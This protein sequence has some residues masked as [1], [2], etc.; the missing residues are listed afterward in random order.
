VIEKRYHNTEIKEDVTASTRK[1]QRAEERR[2]NRIQGAYLRA[3]LQEATASLPLW[4]TD[5]LICKHA[6]P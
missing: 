3:N 5:A 2:K 1:W 6:S 4:L